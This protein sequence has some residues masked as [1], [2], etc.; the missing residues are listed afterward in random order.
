MTLLTTEEFKGGK[1]AVKFKGE[2][3]GFKKGRKPI[4]EK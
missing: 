4:K 3:L 1:V 2:K